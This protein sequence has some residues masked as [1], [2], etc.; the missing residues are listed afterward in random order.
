MLVELNGKA[1][2]LCEP[3]RLGRLH[4]PLIVRSTS[5][6]VI[7]DHVF[8]TLK[9]LNPRWWVPDLLNEALGAPRFRRQVFR[10]FRVEL[11]QKQRT[12]PA[13]WLPWEEGQTEVDA[14]LTW[15]NPPTTVFVEMKYGSPVAPKTTHNNGQAGFAADQLIRNLRVG[16]WECGWF[17][18]QK[19]LNFLPRDFVL[20]LISPAAGHSLISQY[21]DVERLSALMPSAGRLEAF[22]RSPFLGAI[23]FQKLRQVLSEQ[24]RFW[25]RTE[26]GLVEELNRYLHLKQTRLPTP[27][28]PEYRRREKP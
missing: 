3:A 18:E 4:C 24:N 27:F 14:V 23:A 22:P 13:E 25:S 1:G 15:E 9:N 28:K 8:R 16:L 10:R 2:Q 11:W 7:T 17:R 20:I 26:R 5:E 6:D 19:L 12:F 21:R